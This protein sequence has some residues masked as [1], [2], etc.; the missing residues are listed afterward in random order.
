MKHLDLLAEPSTPHSL[1]T[2]LAVRPA[3]LSSGGRSGPA[4]VGL[5][6][7]PLSA[8]AQQ[9]ASGSSWNGLVGWVMFI[10]IAFWIWRSASAWRRRHYGLPMLDQYLA[11]HPDCHP[12]P[13]KVLCHACRSSSLYLR[14]ENSWGAKVHMCRTC[15]TSLYR[16]D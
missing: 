13:G 10:G 6:L 9:G 4:L 15:G 1:P 5:A 12:Q 2:V 7:I 16:S 14:F 11:A 8:N 3:C